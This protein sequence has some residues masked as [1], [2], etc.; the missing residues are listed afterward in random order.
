MFNAPNL[1]GKLVAYQG[2]R[3]EYFVRKK[4][5]W[6]GEVDECG[7]PIPPEELRA[8]LDKSVD[9]YLSNGRTI[10]LKMREIVEASGFSLGSGG[11]ILDF[12]CGSG[13]LIRCLW[14]LS[15]TWEIWGVDISAEH[16]LWCQRYLS[17]P[18][19]FAATTTLPH[20]PF[21]DGSFDL[22]YAGSVF[23]HISDLVEMWVLELKRI[24]RPRGKL[25]VTVHDQH[26]IEMLLKRPEFWLTGLLRSFL[27]R[28]PLKLEE[29]S[30]FSI[31]RS[32]LEAQVFYD[33]DYLRE[34]WSRFLTVVSVTPRAYGY[35][36]AILLEKP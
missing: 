12:G 5:R 18:F 32:P 10:V 7:L 6:E 9:R 16:I 29:T 2:N 17:P 14:D 23:T 22:I 1:S 21:E 36:T 25:Y 33:I 27:A 8:G 4:T 26:T 34:Q 35:Q 31:G 19:R 30:M 11:G 3:E 15:R 20:L 28:S 13:R 24:L